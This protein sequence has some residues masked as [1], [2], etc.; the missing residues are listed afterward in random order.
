MDNKASDDTGNR[1][2]P[3]INLILENGDDY[4]TTTRN[5]FVCFKRMYETGI[6]QVPE[7]IKEIFKDSSSV[8]IVKASNGITLEELVSDGYVGESV[9]QMMMQMGMEAFSNPEVIDNSIRYLNENKLFEN[10]FLNDF[11][12]VNLW[13]L[14]LTKT[15][16]PISSLLNPSTNGKAI[17]RANVYTYQTNY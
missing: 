12:L 5:F 9:G 4:L 11:K 3:Y 17:Q 1:L 16:G 14:T 2:R 6:Y 10:E 13:P 8:Q 7:V 15:L